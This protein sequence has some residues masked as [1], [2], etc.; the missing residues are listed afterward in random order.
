MLFRSHNGKPGGACEKLVFIRNGDPTNYY[1]NLTVSYENTLAD[2]Y[3]SAGSTGWSVKFLYGRRQPT[4]EEWDSVLAGQSIALPDIGS[5][6][7][8]DTFTFYPLW[9]RVYCPGGAPAQ[10]RE[11]QSIKVYFDEKK[12]GA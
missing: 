12:V 4:E 10:V 3:G 1:T 9:I 2:D 11:G 8:A 6:L 7:A 5:T